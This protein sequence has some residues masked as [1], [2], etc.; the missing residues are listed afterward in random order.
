MD[1]P[2]K[3]QARAMGVGPDN[4]GG[5]RLEAGQARN[6]AV[7]DGDGLDEVDAAPAA[8]TLRT[9][10]SKP[11]LPTRRIEIS[12]EMSLRG[13]ERRAGPLSANVP[14]E[15]RETGARTNRAK[16]FW[17]GQMRRAPSAHGPE[18]ER[19]APARGASSGALVHRPHDARIDWV[20]SIDGFETN[21]AV[22]PAIG[23]REEIIGRA[24]LPR[25]ESE[26]VP[27]SSL[28]T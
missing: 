24:P 3:L 6:H 28:G 13:V 27:P 5:Q 2:L 20:A 25:R 15:R 8:E 17:S 19:A 23:D 9:G 22:R 26:N 4:L 10:T 18:R 14:Q 11:K 16:R 1:R 12:P 7:V 21:L